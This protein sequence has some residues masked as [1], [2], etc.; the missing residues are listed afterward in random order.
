M[1]Y[2]GRAALTIATLAIVASPLPARSAH[3]ATPG[4][5][6]CASPGDPAQDAGFV[7]IGGIEHWITITGERCANPVILFLHGG[8]GNTLSPYAHRIFGGWQTHFTLVQWD[9]RGAG[10][11]YGRN[12]PSPDSTLTVE[13]MTTDGLAVAEYVTERLG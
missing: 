6:G 10:R 4:P 9:Q 12:P 13:S 7:R 11:T 3:V 1:I 5:A 8:P 2:M